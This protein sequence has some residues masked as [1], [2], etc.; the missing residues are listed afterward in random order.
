VEG[1]NAKKV[2]LFAK[3]APTSSPNHVDRNPFL[4][5]SGCNQAPRL[6]IPPDFPKAKTPHSQKLTKGEHP[7]TWQTG[8]VHVLDGSPHVSAVNRSARN[9]ARCV[10]ERGCGFSGR[11]GEVFGAEKAENDVIYIYTQVQCIL[12]SQSHPKKLRNRCRLRTSICASLPSS[13]L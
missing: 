12:P 2:R 5:H 9:P 10:Q 3:P 7:L 8:R 4:N 13:Q 11:A 1:S 6:V